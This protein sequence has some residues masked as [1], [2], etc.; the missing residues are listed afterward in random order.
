MTRDE[1]R[2][3]FNARTGGRWLRYQESFDAVERA[4]GRFT[5]ERAARRFTKDTQHE[6]FIVI[7][8]DGRDARVYHRPPPPRRAA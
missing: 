5:V 4:A 3:T 2:T 8:A 1:M 7:C 6:F